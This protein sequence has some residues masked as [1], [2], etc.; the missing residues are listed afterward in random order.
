MRMRHA[1]ALSALTLVVAAG[2]R[3]AVAADAPAAGYGYAGAL[4]TDLDKQVGDALG[5]AKKF[6]LA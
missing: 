2:A 5:R 1:F 6:L 4:G 3:P